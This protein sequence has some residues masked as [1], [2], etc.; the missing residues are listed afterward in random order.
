MDELYEKSKKLVRENIKCDES[1]QEVLTVSVLAILLLKEEYAIKKLPQ[2]L[3]SLRVNYD[4]KTI[5]EQ[6]RKRFIKKTNH[7]YAVIDSEICFKKE[8]IQEV[9]QLLAT[10]NASNQT[11]MIREL[12]QELLKEMRSFPL[13]QNEDFIEKRIGLAVERID[14]SD[15]EARKTNEVIEE[16]LQEYESKKA[17]E[18]LYEY[19]DKNEIDSIVIEKILQ[20]RNGECL[21][22]DS[23]YVYLIEQIMD[24]KILQ[25]TLLNPQTERNIKNGIYYYNTMMEDEGAFSKLNR[26]FSKLKKAITKLHIKEMEQYIQQIQEEIDAFTKKPKKYRLK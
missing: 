10:K 14:I 18:L 23:I 5:Q 2:V 15:E 21:Y 6:E 25:T 12:I 13:K 8:E 26:L 17:L 7:N 16:S 11:G 20:E 4:Q 3:K 19:L 22:V 9:K 24:D 1:L